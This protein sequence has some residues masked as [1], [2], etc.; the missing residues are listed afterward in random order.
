LRNNKQTLMNKEI[1]FTI[2]MLI[3]TLTKAPAT[4]YYP[5]TLIEIR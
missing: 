5:L 2:A 1:D 4:S 3:E